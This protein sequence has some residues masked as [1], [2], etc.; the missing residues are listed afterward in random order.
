MPQCPNDE[1]RA[2]KF[3]RA[4][5]RNS[6]F[7]G[8]EQ[9]EDFAKIAGVS[10]PGRDPRGFE[11]RRTVESGSVALSFQPSLRT[12]WLIAATRVETPGYSHPVL[13]TKF[14]ELREHWV[15]LS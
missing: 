3:P 4:I 14:R 7:G 15:I 13:R 12:R 5:D 9:S 1:R 6:C 10:T 2:W 11:S 8:A